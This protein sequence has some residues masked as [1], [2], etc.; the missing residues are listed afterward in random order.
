MPDPMSP[1]SIVV[2]APSPLL[3]ITVEAAGT[4]RQ[5]I[6]LHAGGQGFWVARMAA[7]LGAEV[8]MCCALGGESGAVLQALIARENVQLL[9][10]GCAAS[11]GAYIHA[12]RADSREE[13]A[14]TQSRPLSRHEADELYGG[15][16][17]HAVEL[18][19]LVSRQRPRLRAGELFAAVGSAGVD[20]GA[21][22]RRTADA[23]QLHLLPC[24]QR[25]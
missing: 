25:L 8:S 9:S 19:G 2:F 4:P 15:A 23:Q 20:V 13:L 1:P 7:L 12:R 21:V 16:Q 6:H 3:T 5:E 10:V 18:V 14:R 17:R 11:N 22:G 24:D